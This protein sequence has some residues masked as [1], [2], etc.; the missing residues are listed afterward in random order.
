MTETDLV[1]NA[2]ALTEIF[3]YWPSF[4]DAEVL[5]M[6]LDRA[7]EDGPSLETQIHV[8]EM[9][10]QVDER[11]FYVLR[12]HTLVT[13]HF[14]NILL[15]NLGWFNNQNSLSGLGI[16]EAREE[17]VDGRAI[18][19]SFGSNYGV[20]AELLCRGAAIVK[21]EPYEPAGKLPLQLTIAFRM[22]PAPP[23]LLLDALA[24]ELMR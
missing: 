4:H 15:R 9:T 3:G 16:Y 24:A 1:A 7:G 22:A 14:A 21:V 13:L 20:E 23:A 8:F 2:D 18:G 19:V 11:G 10:D 12:K 6:C 17:G 5:T